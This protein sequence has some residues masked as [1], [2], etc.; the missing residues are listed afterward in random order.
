[1]ADL[2]TQGDDGGEERSSNA[3]AKRSLSPNPATNALIAGVALSALSKLSRDTVETVFGIKQDGDA[4]GEEPAKPSALQAIAA[5]GATKL[6]TRSVPGF[7]LVSSGLIAKTLFDR[8]QTKR[9]A[10]RAAQKTADGSTGDQ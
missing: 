9:K 1:M 5:A 6:A 8:S 3:P 2:E 10:K 7:A 4:D